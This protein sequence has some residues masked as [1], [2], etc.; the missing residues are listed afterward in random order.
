MTKSCSLLSCTPSVNA[1]ENGVAKYWSKRHRKGSCRIDKIRYRSVRPRRDNRAVAHCGRGVIGRSSIE[2]GK[3]LH[4]LDVTML[5]AG[6]GA[7][8]QQHVVQMDRRHRLGPRNRTCS[9]GRGKLRIRFRFP[10][11]T[12]PNSAGAMV[13][14]R[15]T[16]RIRERLNRLQV[17]PQMPGCRAPVQGGMIVKDTKLPRTIVFGFTD[18]EKPARGEK[19][20]LILKAES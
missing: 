19:L 6:I 8:P 9:A 2:S 10:R 1:R 14:T 3:R 4:V 7:C 15:K 17:A 16:A 12:G 5:L 18:H 20:V 11:G 13:G